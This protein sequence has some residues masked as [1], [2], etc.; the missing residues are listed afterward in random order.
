MSSGLVPLHKILKDETRR[1]IVLLLD[2]KINLSYTDLINS[3]GDVS[4]GLLNYHLKVLNDLLAKNEAGQYIL[5]EKG[6]LA[7]KLII[8]F[9]E[10]DGPL[11]K[12]KR[13]QFWI[14]AVVVQ[15]VYLFSSITLYSLN[16]LDLG[17]FVIYTILF[18]GSIGLSYFGYRAQ[19]KNQPLPGSNEEKKRSRNAYIIVGCVTGLVSGF[20]GPTFFILLFQRFL[21]KS[22][23]YGL[24]NSGELWISFMVIGPLAGTIIGYY[25]GKRNKFAKPKWVTWMED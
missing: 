2:E 22:I 1:R 25:I 23:L 18:I 8:E 4:T 19:I 24:L 11:Q 3:L 10:K 21:S 15:L 13:K 12:K 9:P 16:Y 17:R 20:F 14:L 7:S 6:K 5:T